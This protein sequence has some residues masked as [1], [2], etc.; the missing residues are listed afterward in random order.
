M[1]SR[2]PFYSRSVVDITNIQSNSMRMTLLIMQACVLNVS[3]CVDL[4]IFIF[5]VPAQAGEA[6]GAAEAD[7]EAGAEAAIPS[8]LHHGR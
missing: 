6:A 3:E 8:A 4:L 2:V 7:R 1:I 5:L